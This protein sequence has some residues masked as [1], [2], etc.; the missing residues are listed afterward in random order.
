MKTSTTVTTHVHVLFYSVLE[1]AFLH[2]FTLS[3][4]ALHSLMLFPIFV[5]TINSLTHAI[6]SGSDGSHQQCCVP[7]WRTEERPSHFRLFYA[8]IIEINSTTITYLV[9][10]SNTN[11][12][13]WLSVKCQCMAESQ[14]LN[15]LIDMQTF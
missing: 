5:I 10:H 4:N 8:N 11:Y 14:S 1:I 9:L 15:K 6:P 3:H 12:K 7:Y 2:Q 13:V